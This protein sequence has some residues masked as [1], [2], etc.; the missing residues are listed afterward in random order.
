[1]LRGYRTL[2]FAALIWSRDA[3]GGEREEKARIQ[4]EDADR[5]PHVQRQVSEQ[6][7]LRGNS[8]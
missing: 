1:M 7:N 2:I 4:A 5:M 8:I 6:G 3:E